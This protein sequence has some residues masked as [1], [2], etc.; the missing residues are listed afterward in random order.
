[1]TWALVFAAAAAL[2]PGCIP[3]EEDRILG[4]HIAAAQPALSAFEKAGMIGL[5]PVPGVRRR[6]SPAELARLASRHGITLPDATAINEVCFERPSTVL[7]EEVLTAAMRAA[8]PAEAQLEVVDFCRIPVPKGQLEFTKSGLALPPGGSV[9]LPVIWRGR[10]RYSKF[11]S[12]P[13]WAKVKAWVRRDRVV[14]GEA[15]AAGVP[16]EARQLRLESTDAPPFSPPGPS[17]IEEVA[18]RIL[19][20]SLPAGQ[21]VPAA[22]I[23]A[24]N[25]V[26][27]GQTVAVDVLSGSAHLK[28]QAKA[29]SGG[30]AGDTVVVR[31][32]ENNRRFRARVSGKGSVVVNETGGA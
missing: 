9:R 19:R 22:S 17:R 1:M 26:E 3:I 18:G 31:N 10:L 8:L 27:R 16:I 28:F 4:S 14:A 23:S 32:P 30:R 6:F 24:P 25:D 15:V 5:T 11:R 13:V 21:P 12:V 20:R 7:T 29:E 2:T